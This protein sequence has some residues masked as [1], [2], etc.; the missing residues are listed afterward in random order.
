M[1]QGARVSTRRR[2]AAALL[3]P[4][5]SSC[6]ALTPVGGQGLGLRAHAP[7]RVLGRVTGTTAPAPAAAGQHPARMRAVREKLI[8]TQL[9]P[10]AGQAQYLTQF[11]HSVRCATHR[12]LAVW[13]RSHRSAERHRGGAAGRGI[14]QQD[15]SRRRRRQQEAVTE[16]GGEGG[17]PDGCAAARLPPQGNRQRVPVRGAPPL[18]K[19]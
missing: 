12:R 13:R 6:R 3:R 5:C 4:R 11:R 2:W 8:N 9:Q 10:A 16:C 15:S 18:L 14:G 7:G 19:C 17:R 1:G